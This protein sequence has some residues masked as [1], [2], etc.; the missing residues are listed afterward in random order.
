MDSCSLYAYAF[1]KR[2]F[3]VYAVLPNSTHINDFNPDCFKNAIFPCSGEDEE[4]L[5]FISQ[6]G[7]CAGVMGIRSF[8]KRQSPVYRI[9][10][11]LYT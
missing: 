1:R 6:V 8:T 5:K 7:V 9:E 10:S 4:L 11:C 3:L 2:A